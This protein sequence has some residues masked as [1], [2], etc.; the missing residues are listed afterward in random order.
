MAFRIEA[1]DAFRHR[2]ARDESRGMRTDVI[3]YASQAM[4]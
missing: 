4:L 2:I 3:V 1:L